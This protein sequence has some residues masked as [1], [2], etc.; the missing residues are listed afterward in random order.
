MKYA[1]VTLPE[2]TVI[3]RQGD[4]SY[5][6]LT[7]GVQYSSGGQFQEEIHQSR[8]RCNHWSAISG[9]RSAFP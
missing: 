2:R 1:S 4:R 7:T 3:V 6:Y 5:V 9:I 8:R